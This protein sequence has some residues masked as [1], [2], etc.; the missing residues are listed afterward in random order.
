M[1]STLKS[2][3][4]IVIRF[5]GMCNFKW[6]YN[7]YIGKSCDTELLRTQLWPKNVFVPKLIPSKHGLKLRI[8]AFSEWKPHKESTKVWASRI[9]NFTE[10]IFQRTFHSYSYIR[11]YKDK[12]SLKK[13]VILTTIVSVM[14]SHLKAI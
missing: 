11:H 5:Y 3:V 14:V 6:L 12:K 13:L 1:W 8:S 9:I 10:W 2:F 4:L 7:I